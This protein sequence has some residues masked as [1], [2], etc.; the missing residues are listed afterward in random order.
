MKFVFQFLIIMA[1]AF[2][3]ELLHHFIPLPIPAS[4]YGIVLLYIALELKLVKVKDI[5]ET[6]SFLI[7]IMPIM[8]LPPAVG[9]VQSWSLIKGLWL[10]CAVVIVVSTVVVMAVSGRL[11]QRLVR[12]GGRK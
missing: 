9:I 7:S 1:F 6:S 12:K 4:I 11:T 10:P 3:G 2:A 8:F 5:K